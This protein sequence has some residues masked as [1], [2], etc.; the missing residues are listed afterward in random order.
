MYL[1]QDDSVGI[2]IDKIN[3]LLESFIGINDA[4]LGKF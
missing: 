4:E 3:S 2:A 1:Q